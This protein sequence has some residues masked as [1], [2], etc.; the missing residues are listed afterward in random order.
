[1][2][3]PSK[4]WPL[5]GDQWSQTSYL[6]RDGTL[7]FVEND[8]KEQQYTERPLDI[9]EFMQ[10]HGAT[11]SEPEREIVAFLTAAGLGR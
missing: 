5:R 6:F 9:P 8:N 1:M 10:R 2:A 3:E 7:Y 4:S 11:T